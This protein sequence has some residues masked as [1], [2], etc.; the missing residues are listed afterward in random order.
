MVPWHPKPHPTHSSSKSSVWQI[1]A[2]NSSQLVA[3][4][5]QREILL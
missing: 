4:P 1:G 3:P 5:Q 2:Q